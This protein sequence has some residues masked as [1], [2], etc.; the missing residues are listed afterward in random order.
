MPEFVIGIDLGTTNSALAFAQ[1]DEESRVQIFAIPQLAHPGEVASLDLLPSSLYIAGPSE[2]VEGALALPW[3]PQPQYIVGR[4][5][6]VRGTENAN[7]LVN[8]AKSWLSHQTA[9]PTEPLLPLTAPEG[10]TK[11]SAVEASQQYL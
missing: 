3:N 5:A 6:R 1:K 10:I 8:S 2:F 7:R 4:L 9:D 11:I